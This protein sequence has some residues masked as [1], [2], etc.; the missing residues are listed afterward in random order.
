[1]LQKPTAYITDGGAKQHSRQGGLIEAYEHPPMVSLADSTAR[2]SISD[3]RSSAV[4][5]RAH[6]SRDAFRVGG[7]WELQ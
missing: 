7:K 4:T 6:M 3:T 5:C 2:A 1:M